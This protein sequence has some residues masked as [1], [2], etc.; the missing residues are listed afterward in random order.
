M[1]MLAS[2][3]YSAQWTQTNGPPG[4]WIT[5]GSILMTGGN[6]VA[7]TQ[8]NGM[9]LSR[10]RGISWTRI[11]PD[12]D[13]IYEFAVSGDYAFVGTR[14]GGVLRSSDHGVTW[15]RMTNGVPEYIET[16]A[17]GVNKIYAGL[18]DVYVSTDQGDSWT[19][20][21][22]DGSFNTGIS[23]MT[24]CGNDLFAAHG[25]EGVYASHDDG[26]TWT[27][28]TNELAGKIVITLTTFGNFVYAGTWDY[29]VFRSDD[30]GASWIQVNNGLT[31]LTITSFIIHGATLFAGTINGGVC[32]TENYG[33]LWTTANNG[34]NNYLGVLTLSANAADFALGTNGG[35]IYTSVNAG[36]SWA[37][38]YGLPCTHITSL[39]VQGSSVFA[40][41]FSDGLFKSANNGGTWI[42]NGQ[43]IPF[44]ININTLMVSEPNIY[45]GTTEGIYVSS[46]NGN[47]WKAINTGFP[48]YVNI[49][50]ILSDGTHLFAG[51]NNF[52]VYISNNLGASWAP[53]NNG[54]SFMSVGS[55]VKK[56]GILFAGTGGGV[57]KSTDNGSTWSSVNQGL[58]DLCVNALTIQGINI[59]A[60]TY[61][62]N[63]GVFTSS[64]DGITWHQKLADLQ[65][66]SF[67][68][69]GTELLASSYSGRIFISYD[70]GETWIENMDELPSLNIYALATSGK[71]LFAGTV[72]NGVYLN[73]T[74]LTENKE[75]AADLLLGRIFPNPASNTFTI[76]AKDIDEES[77]LTLF[78]THG[79]IL[80]DQQITATKSTVNVSALPPGAYI[81]R[82]TN[83]TNTEVAKLIKE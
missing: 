76:E 32:K 72:E 75:V 15:S 13:Y 48:D 27:N 70:Q 62:E 73:S 9:Y 80:L 28:V 61:C 51:T 58:T 11:E 19:A 64:D 50:A 12:I 69:S 46:N 66:T 41:T 49:N 59:I 56:N 24:V 65:I 8:D 67:A 74:I 26:H 40:G 81:L 25:D 63:G 22:G 5:V 55:L 44:W 52:G 34:L 1:L 20:A 36:N 43:G 77:Q 3:G 18:S 35:E 54:L 57:F 2:W 42:E 37:A 14:W 7:G 17:V 71:M 6:I 10:D 78:N 33:D 29:G 53:V 21:N 16:F 47:S 83:G 30:H 39:A 82:Y 23:S 4:G 45:A 31:N 60:G 38:S 68:K 79:Q